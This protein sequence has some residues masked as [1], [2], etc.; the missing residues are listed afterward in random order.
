MCTYL[1]LS[2]AA[3]C[4][5][6]LLAP[7]GCRPAAGPRA[8]GSGKAPVPTPS[9]DQ[10]TVLLANEGE[11][12]EAAGK[13]GRRVRITRIVRGIEGGGTAATLQVMQGKRTVAYLDVGVTPE[14]LRGFFRERVRNG[15][16]VRVH[17]DPH[18]YVPP[19]RDGGVTIR[20]TPS[21]RFYVT[22]DRRKPVP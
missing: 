21:D 20:Q 16:F 11:L 19:R 10:P 3:L 9:A 13:P 18:P 17:L 22:R 7:V 1:A 4:V 12:L 8:T 14:R 5:A 15:Q 2:L 6:A